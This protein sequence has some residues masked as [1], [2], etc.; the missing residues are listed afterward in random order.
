MNPEISR[1]AGITMRFIPWDEKDKFA[2]SVE[3]AKTL[4]DIPQPWR[5]LMIDTKKK[6]G[7]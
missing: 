5:N 4:Q 1:L 6:L 2:S 7:K 3:K